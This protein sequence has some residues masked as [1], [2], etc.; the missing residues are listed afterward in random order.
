MF[1]RSFKKNKFKKGFTLIELMV[2]IA[3]IAL[4]ASIVITTLSEAKQRAQ[5]AK[6]KATKQQVQLVL[7]VYYQ[8]HG[9]YPNPNPGNAELYC[10]GGDD[11][12]LNNG[13][14]QYTVSTPLAFHNSPTLA[15]KQSM[16]ASPAFTFPTLTGTM[17]NIAGNRGIIYASCGGNLTTCPQG[18]AQLLSATYADALITQTVGNWAEITTYQGTNILGCTDPTAYNYDSGAT[19]D[20]GSCYFNPG[21]TDSSATNY[22]SDAD[23]DDGSCHY[24]SNYDQINYPYAFTVNTNEGCLY[25]DGTDA[26]GWV[27]SGY[28]YCA[29]TS[30]TYYNSGIGYPYSGYGPS[31]QGN[32]YNATMSNYD[33]QTYPYAFSS[34]TYESCLYADG[35]YA[36]GWNGNG[37]Y[38]CA[39]TSYT[40]FNSNYGSYTSGNG[41]QGSGNYYNSFYTYSCQGSPNNI[42]CP[43]YNYDQSSCSTGTYGFCSFTA[44]QSFSCSLNNNTSNCSNFNGDEYSCN[45]NSGCSWNYNNNHSCSGKYHP[46]DCINLDES[47]CSMNSNWCDYTPSGASSC[48]STNKVCSDITDQ[49]QCGYAGCSWQ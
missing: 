27:G 6:V 42:Y 18:T 43:N 11:C 45:A 38:Y 9:G 10:V 33:Q 19:I 17:P 16:V 15:K 21:C 14:T 12:L 4:L 30:Y 31:G 41:P 35:Y 29:N 26:T 22:N 44:G 28:Y 47:S 20:N 25:A 8:D 7:D 37:Y 5:D 40:H 13:E 32:Y 48:N 46:V 49:S 34:D 36:T 39:N 3:I 1:A 2:A 24:I 23:Y